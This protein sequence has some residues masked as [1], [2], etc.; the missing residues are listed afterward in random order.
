MAQSEQALGCAALLSAIEVMFPP[1][2]I[3][4]A[5]AASA[6]LSD[7]HARQGVSIAELV[8]ISYGYAEMSHPRDDT[9]PFTKWSGRS[10]SFQIWMRCFQTLQGA[11]LQL[12][13]HPSALSEC[14]VHT[15]S[16]RWRYVAACWKGC[17]WTLDRMQ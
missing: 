14:F 12:P 2:S 10:K 17:S 3:H 7:P 4:I 9:M 8:P 13:S 6:L 16:I 15:F 5:D 11:F 1:G